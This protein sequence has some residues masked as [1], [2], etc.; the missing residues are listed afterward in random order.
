MDRICLFLRKNK[1]VDL[2]NAGLFLSSRILVALLQFL[3][4][5]VHIISM[6]NLHLKM[7]SRFSALL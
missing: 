1:S 7:N 2:Y 6:A 4:G 3:C 5:E